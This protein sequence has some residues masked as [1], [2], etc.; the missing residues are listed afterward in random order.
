MNLT[1]LKEFLSSVTDNS[2]G[3]ELNAELSQVIDCNRLLYSRQ[4]N[5]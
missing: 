5:R 3:K 1:S 2:R 4:A